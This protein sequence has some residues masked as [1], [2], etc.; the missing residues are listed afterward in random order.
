MKRIGIASI[1]FRSEGFLTSAKE[2]LCNYRSLFR[3][4]MKKIG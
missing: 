3:H 1:G 2:I 4:L